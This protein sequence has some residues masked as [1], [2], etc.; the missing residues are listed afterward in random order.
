MNR[1]AFEAWAKGRGARDIDF[2]IK[3]NGHYAASYIDAT[4]HAWS[5]RDAEVAALKARVE[6]LESALRMILIQDQFLH[7]D[8]TGESTYYYNSFDIDVIVNDA[9]TGEEG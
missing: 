7:R 9:L 8:P 3:S 4:W 2:E 5:A 6:E 1:E